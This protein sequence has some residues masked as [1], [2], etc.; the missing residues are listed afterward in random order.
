MRRVSICLCIVVIVI[1]FNSNF[2]F[3]NGFKILGIK[4]TKASGM[5]EAFIAQADD[6]SAITFNPAGLTQV[7][8]TQISLGGTI[9]NGW[10][11]YTSQEDE[12]ED[13]IDKW[14][15]APAVFITSD[16][17]ME[18]FV[19]GIGVT[20]PNGISSE[21]EEDSFARYVDTF[22]ELIL[23][24]INPSLSCKV[25]DNL[26]VGLGVSY[27]YST[28]TLESMVDYGSLIGFPGAF[29]GKNK[30][31]GKGNTWGY[32]VGILYKPNERHSFAATF[33][34]PITVDYK[35][36]TE[37]TDIPF[38]MGLGSSFDSDA[39]TSIDFPAVVVLGYAYRPIDRLKLEFNLDW[40]NWETLD[41]IE[42]DF[43]SPLLNDVTYDYEYKNTFAYK[44]GLEYLVNERLS[45]RG[46]YIYNENAT[47][48]EK[49]R[50]S[51]PD[52]N[53]HFLTFGFGYA[54]DRFTIDGAL[55]LVFYEDREIDNNVDNNET[56]TS[57]SIDGEYENF[58]VAFAVG[59]TYKF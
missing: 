10:C 18:N 32:N 35:G 48:E 23:I 50:P 7:D 14:Q 4:S 28:A 36:E 34:S 33:K 15:T 45:M 1:I 31:E 3:A 58:G 26:S 41:S 51:L 30:L 49:W 5:G 38:F 8:G 55:E 16:F 47:S 2:S 22:S 44:L 53:S 46:G 59:I 9:M 11:Q 24:D 54:M 43:E 37:F 20:A 12:E 29:D 52:T 17:G 13:M 56:L 40:T 39:E 25:N 57:S 21:W 27:Y 42:V 6:P 19:A